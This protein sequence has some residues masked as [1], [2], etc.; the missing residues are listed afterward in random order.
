MDF[1]EANLW[2]LER[3]R[4]SLMRALEGLTP[5]QVAWRACATCNSTGAMVIHLG[6][7]EDTWVHRL[8]GGK[9]IWETEGWC[10]KLGLPANDRGWTYDKQSAQEKRPLAELV[11]YYEATHRLLARTVQEFP[12]NRFDEAFANPANFTVSQMFSHLII[13]ENQH[14]GQIDY[15]KGLQRSQQ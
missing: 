6:R 13:E 5:Q 11:A 7:V 4:A 10:Q 9:D 12:A 3:T 15:L 8:I 2:S 1:R 14:V